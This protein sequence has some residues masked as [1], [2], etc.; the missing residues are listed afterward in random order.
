[1]NSNPVFIALIAAL[2][3]LTAGCVAEAP[4]DQPAPPPS[5]EMLTFDQAND[6]ETVTLDTGSR[7]AI[8]LPENPTTGYTWD[9][10]V[11]PGIALVDDEFIPEETGLMGAPG[12]HI[13]TFEARTPGTYTI[14]GKDIRPWEPEAAPADTF[15][16]TVVVT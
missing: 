15:T 3:L 2:L 9:L 7:F 6:G 13:W 14:D 5:P 4:D 8:S 1:M 16:L 11:P 12:T 10:D